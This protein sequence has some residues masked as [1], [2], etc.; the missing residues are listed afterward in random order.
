VKQP[1]DGRGYQSGVDAIVGLQVG[2]LFWEMVASTN[3]LASFLGDGRVDI[4]GKRAFRH[5]L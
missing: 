3:I 2:R 1:T 5:R 4:I